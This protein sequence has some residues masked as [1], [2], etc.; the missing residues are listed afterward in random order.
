MCQHNVVRGMCEL[1][2]SNVCTYKAG[3]GLSFCSGRGRLGDIDRC[4]FACALALKT[5]MCFP[6][7][8]SGRSWLPLRPRD[9]IGVPLSSGVHLLSTAPEVWPVS[10]LP[11]GNVDFC[12]KR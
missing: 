6:W 11:D 1:Y 8:M 5:C 10:V 2:L 9:C 7:K 3:R 12:A 4:R